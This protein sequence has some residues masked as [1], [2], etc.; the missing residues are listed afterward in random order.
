[1]LWANS[2]TSL[3]RGANPKSGHGALC[4]L[5]DDGFVMVN[6]A[7]RMKT[8]GHGGRQTEAVPSAAPSRGN[9]ASGLILNVT[10]WKSVA[11]VILR[12]GLIAHAEIYMINIAEP[13]VG[14]AVGRSEDVSRIRIGVVGIGK[15]A[16]DQHIPV[17]R[18]NPD[19]ALGATTSEHSR[20]DGIENF[21]TVEDML[22]GAE[23]DAVAI[24]TPPQRH[25]EMA[26]KCLAAGKHV[27]LEK[28]PCQST[29]ELEIL[30]EL[31]ARERVT[32][33]QTWH[34]RFAPCVDLAAEILAGRQIRAVSIAWKEDVRLWHPG[35][36]W[37]FKAGGFGVFDPG[38][39]A[40]SILTKI[41]PDPVFV[42]G[43]TLFVP[44]NCETPITAELA[45][46]S[47]TGTAISAIFDFR[48][49]G[50]QIWDI[51]VETDSGNLVL[52]R[53][54]AALELDGKS[55]TPNGIAQ[56]NHAEYAPLYRRFAELIRRGQSDADARPFRLVADAFLVGRRVT[57]EAFHE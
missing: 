35:Q 32:L 24:C 22:G 57:V 18:R 12:A 38:I 4:E 9:P 8:T 21:A 34:S 10:L 33:F 48:Q 51:R 42:T 29:T 56:D 5:A 54:G 43:A 17:L 26:N 45:L 36:G 28:P 20:L 30:A 25:F 44:E 15:I 16:R 46:R 50:T 14:L 41:L 13:G 11:K 49:T 55:L 6:A 7:D 1:M 39:N 47:E 19:F 37:I 2:A 31:A 27:L 3:F 53:G 52:S 23:L 40:L